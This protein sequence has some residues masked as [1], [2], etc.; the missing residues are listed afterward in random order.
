M[1]KWLVRVFALL[2]S[3]ICLANYA[4]ASKNS[5]VYKSSENESN[6]IA[7]TFDDGPHP[8][9]TKKILDVLEKYS[10]KATFFVIG[11]NAKNY[12]EALQQ[13]INSGHEIGNHTYSHHIL[14]SKTKDSI[15]REILDTEKEISKKSSYFTTLVRPPCGIF[16]ST[17]V[18]IAN[19]N[20]YKI[21]LWS[22][23]TNDWA[24]AGSNSIVEA[25]IKNVKGGD[26]ILFHDYTSGENNTVEALN[27]LIPKLQKMG[28][29]L[30]TV[31]ELLE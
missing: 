28:Y 14:K 23:D 19:E 13:V 30:V 22:I 27:I 16:D 20:G 25:V 24:H 21:V 29:E 31:S 2:C 17:L 1:R 6:K 12:P 9:N 11:V 8:R 7:I 5:P 26:I 3:I 4:Y 10:V 18:D 15:I